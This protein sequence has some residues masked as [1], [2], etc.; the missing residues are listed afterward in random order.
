MQKFERPE[1]NM[2]ECI[3][4]NMK[5]KVRS[6]VTKSL[7]GIDL[8]V[9]QNLLLF[10][11]QAEVLIFRSRSLNIRTI[12]QSVDDLMSGSRS[13]LGENVDV[14]LI[15]RGLCTI[16]FSVATWE[17]KKKASF[18]FDPKLNVQDDG[19]MDY[20]LFPQHTEKVYSL[21]CFSTRQ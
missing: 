9:Q 16:C 5:S 4:P 20:K 1:P 3:Y 7:Y 17:R 14:T 18:H 6:D 12:K 19:L 21:S 11:L 13:V 2:F 15:D 8:S 10:L